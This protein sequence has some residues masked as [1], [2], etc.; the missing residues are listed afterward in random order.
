MALITARLLWSLLDDEG[1]RM[2]NLSTLDESHLERALELARKAWGKTHPNPMVGAVVSDGERILSEG[3]HSSAGDAH[4]EVCALRNLNET[5]SSSAVLYVT[6]EPCSTHGRTPPC[7]DAIVESGIGRV[8]VGAQDP[9]PIHAGRG[10][11]L[12]RDAGVEVLEASGSIAD[13]CKDINM[14]FDYCI[15]SQTPFFALKLAVS[16]N[17]MIAEEKGRPSQVTGSMARADVMRWRRLFPAIAVGA[18]TI[19]SDNPRLTARFSDEEWCPR[20]IILD[21]NLSS[22]PLSGEMPRVYSDRFRKKTLVVMGAESSELSSRVSRLEELGVSILHLSADSSNRF[23][24]SDLRKQLY[25]EGLTGVFFEGGGEVARRLVE[26]KELD[27]LFCYES[28]KYFTGKNAVKAPPLSV[29]SSENNFRRERYGEDLLLRGK[30]NLKQLC[31]L[32]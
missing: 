23:K 13:D 16:A 6:L 19:R 29:F 9:N 18:G 20:R 2:S 25:A 17:G 8:V 5:I 27:Y 24:F 22:V 31:D 30:L 10:L 21:G 15:R 3:Y 14:I 32:K 28:T 11:R 7:V 4:A 26:E 1:F 12:L